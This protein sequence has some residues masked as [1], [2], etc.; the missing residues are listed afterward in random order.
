[1]ERL[2]WDR[3]FTLARCRHQRE[4]G[5]AAADS[6][7][8]R[9]T[10]HPDTHRRRRA[11]GGFDVTH[12][13]PKISSWQDID[14][15]LSKTGARYSWQVAKVDD[16]HCDPV[17]G[18]NTGESLPLASIFKLYVLHAVADAVKER[19][20]VVGRSADRH[21]QEPGGRV[22]RH[23]IACGGAYFGSH[24]RR[25]D[26]RHQRQ[27]GDRLADRQGWARTPWRRRWSRPAI[28]IRPH[29]AVSHDVRAVLRRLGSTGF[30]R[31][32][33]SRGHPQVRARCWRRRIRLPTNRIRLARPLS[34]VVIRRGMVWQRRGHL[35]GPR[36][37]AGRRGRRGG[38]GQADP[39]CGVRVLSWIATFGLTSQRK[40][41]A[42]RVT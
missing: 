11:G 10:R 34:G 37:A 22:L 21:R 4:R 3:P 9:A 24:G 36:G 32:S 28:T 15:V 12:R 39:F 41:V 5:D 30:A 35:P 27:H 20:G 1:M 40:P 2:W 38:P 18:T 31:A 29:D 26:D 8:R 19:D 7:L 14:A 16:G 23:G 13:R 42:C 25:E 6:V 33:G 17:A